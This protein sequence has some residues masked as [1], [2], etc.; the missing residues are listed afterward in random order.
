MQKIFFITISFFCF[1]AVSFTVQASDVFFIPQNSEHYNNNTLIKDVYLDTN[2]KYINV[3]KSKI[4][5]NSDVLEAID[6]I[7][8]ESIIKLWTEN[9]VISNK[10]GFVKFSGGIPNGHK[11][12][13]LVLKIIFKTKNEGDCKL[14][15][16]ETKIFLNDGKGERDNVNIIGNNCNI[17]E[18]LEDFT[19]IT[20]GSHPDENKWYNNNH[21][22]LRWDLIKDA[23][24]SYLLSRDFSA[25][26][27]AI[28]DTPEGDLIWMG[29]MS[30][31]GL[32]DGIYYFHLRQKL[33]NEEWSRKITFRAMID[34]ERPKELF[35]QVAD[36]EGKKYLVFNA[37]DKTSGVDYYEVAEV[38]ENG[39]LKKTKK[40]FDWK[41]ASSPY[42]LEDQE[43][44]SIFKIK[45]IDKA[46]N[47]KEYEI[48]PAEKVS[49]SPQIL[50][51][52]LLVI[53]LIIILVALRLF[54]KK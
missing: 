54:R 32:E 26:P 44:E 37:E 8:G 40:E 49:I 20:S 53:M 35:V 15:F 50:A 3:I 10:E 16:S 14:N 30:Y 9:P 11:G 31:R 18:E 19:K 36:I 28:A 39:L 41:N 38:K 48:S 47:K 6:I 45:A 1:M 43:L 46:G 42:L 22:N 17:I 34:I 13:G 21:L 33:P 4:I 2:D 7:K 51:F 12:S 5:F 23:E 52:L 27:D 25:I 29:S 24:Y